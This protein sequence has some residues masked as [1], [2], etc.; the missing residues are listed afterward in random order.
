VQLFGWLLP[1]RVL[2]V[3]MYD[4]T[5]NLLLAMLMHAT[6][7]ASMLILQPLGISG[8]MLLKYVLGLA[9]A[10]WTIVGIVAV[11][12]RGRFARPPLGPM[13]S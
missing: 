11:V 7:T 1:F 8:A 13:T 2:I 9:I 3:W 10:Y 5:N 6:V 12:T 4:G